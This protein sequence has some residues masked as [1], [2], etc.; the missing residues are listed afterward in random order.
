MNIAIFASAFYPHFGGVEEA[1]RH[2]ALEYQ[3]RGHRAHIITTRHPSDLPAHETAVGIDV[4][5]FPFEMPRTRPAGLA[6]FA[7]AF[8]AERRSIANLLKSLQADIIHVQCVS[9]NGFYALWAAQDTGLPMVVTTQGERT[10]DAGQL[11]QKS[12][13]A[14]WTLKTLLRR[15]DYI[16]ACSQQTLDDIKEFAGFSIESKSRAIYNGIDLDE[17]DTDKTPYVH[18][19]PYIL[20]IGRIVPQKGFDILIDAYS[21][22]I[23]RLASAPDLIIAGDGP[24]REK[25]Q[26]QID[27]LGLSER[28][29]LIGRANRTQ[30]VQLFHGC[31]FFV[32]PSRQEPQGIVSLEA[33][34]CAKPVVA[35]RVGGVPE[36]VL[37]G[38]TGLLFSGGDAVALAHTLEKTICDEDE[39]KAMG[40]AGRARAEAH[41][42][43][44]R[45]ADQYFEIYNKVDKQVPCRT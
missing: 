2:L 39:A 16:T 31:Q 24:E 27:T 4:W 34:A 40:R 6:H 1:C 10:M 37:D 28:I 13:A 8:P 41:F 19:R 11:Y 7:R 23:Y 33:M 29:H 32:L 5:R 45:I 18:P 25:L 42:T 36:I 22:L 30:T 26:A 21:R 38:E 43:W 15:A 12:L 44:P 35:A 9:A 20:G 17:F 14:N 3:R